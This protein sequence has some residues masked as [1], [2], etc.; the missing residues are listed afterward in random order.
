MRPKKEE[1]KDCLTIRLS[2]HKFDKT[3]NL[4]VY[5]IT[6]IETMRKHPHMMN[7]EGIFRKSGSI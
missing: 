4:P 6:L 5:L 3:H 2:R 1:K 7:L